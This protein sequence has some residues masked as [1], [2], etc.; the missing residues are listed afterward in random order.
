MFPSAVT[1][2]QG[3]GLQLGNMPS[4]RRLQKEGTAAED[5]ACG[6]VKGYAPAKCLSSELKIRLSF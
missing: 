3:H 4:S 5:P 1:F 2:M 6:A